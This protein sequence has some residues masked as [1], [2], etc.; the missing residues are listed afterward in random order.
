MFLGKHSLL[1]KDKTKFYTKI[2][3]L[4]PFTKYSN[5]SWKFLEDCKFRVLENEPQ[6]DP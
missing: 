1:Y 4:I 3:K 5:W 6:D 2:H